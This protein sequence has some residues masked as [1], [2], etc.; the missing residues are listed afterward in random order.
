MTDTE[1]I[2]RSKTDEQLVEASSGVA[3]FTEEGERVVRAELR[4]RGLPEP[5]VA[6]R[7]VDAE[8]TQE[9]DLRRAGKI[10]GWLLLPAIA[11]VLAPLK[12][13]LDTSPYWTTA[14]ST[15]EPEAA[16][17]FA[18]GT[19]WVAVTLVVGGF[20]FRKH[21][22]APRLYIAWIVLNILLGTLN[23]IDWT[24]GAID[25]EATSRF[26]GQV[27]WSVVWISYFVSSR[28]VKLTFLDRGRPQQP[29]ASA[30]GNENFNRNAAEPARALSAEAEPVV[31]GGQ[32]PSIPPSNNRPS[33]TPTAHAPSRWG[34]RFSRRAIIVGMLVVAVS[35]AAAWYLLLR[36]L[37]PREIAARTLPSVVLLEAQDQDGTV[38]ATG[39]G[40]FVA[41][42]TVA[43]NLHVVEGAW[44]ARVMLV[45]SKEWRGVLGLLCVDRRNDLALIDVA[46]EMVPALQVADRN[47]VS[48][49]DEVFVV[50]NP[51]GLSGTFSQGQVSA[52]RE[53]GKQKLI[54]ITAPISEGSSG[55]PV[56][57][58]Q[59]RV[60]AIAVG[61][62]RRGQSLNFAVPASDLQRLVLQVLR[63][64]P[65]VDPLI[66]AVLGAHRDR[67]RENLLGV[68]RTVT[69]WNPP[70][71]SPPVAQTTYNVLGNRIENLE[72]SDYNGRT[73]LHVDTYEYDA[74]HRLVRKTDASGEDC[75]Y[76]RST[77]GD[78][79][80]SC[81]FRGIPDFSTETVKYDADGRVLET[82]LRVG[83]SPGIHES[84][85]V[86]TYTYVAGR[87][88]AEN[89]SG[90]VRVEY[91]WDARGRQVEVR[92]FE[93]SRLELR[94]VP[95]T[96]DEVGNWTSAVEESHS[97]TSGRVEQTRITRRITYYYY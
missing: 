64:R 11:I 76:V 95:D 40:F 84:R 93:S 58:R 37:Q 88:V 29:K 71:S 30:C 10:A 33:P 2:W 72:W 19:V 61:A 27:F 60:A 1:K 16:V 52:F 24:T 69:Q 25:N 41:R 53:E 50:G 96:Y 9:Q 12:A 56:V 62:A 23:L 68:V 97:S 81:A 36:P 89:Y 18:V 38:I 26:I 54:Q 20:F 86:T 4:R 80:G 67:E 8:G 5:P 77:D 48:V 49:G 44:K 35:G 55:S 51:E 43:T 78:Q 83:G 14:F 34:A 63:A 28:R 87:L 94:I 74:E 13:I 42:R 57:D 85:R 45:Q 32:A 70:H 46:D 92:M 15:S 21:R 75:G 6:E 79:V 7:V 91:D 66:T 73:F 17:A 65:S 59:G 39:T 47:S 82:R 31:V 22:W 90:G 3:Q